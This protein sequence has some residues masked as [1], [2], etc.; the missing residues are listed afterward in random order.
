MAKSP[1]VGRWAGNVFGTNTGRVLLDLEE[2]NGRLQGTIRI[3]DSVTGLAMYSCSGDTGDVLDLEITPVSAQPGVEVAG[4]RV[5]GY[6]R[7]DG[8]VSGD[9]ETVAGTAGTFQVF[10]HTALMD[11][12]EGPMPPVAPEQ[13]FNS[14]E[15][16]GAMRLYL[17]DLH[18][19]FELVSQDFHQAR[20]VVTYAYRGSEK[21][22]YSDAFEADAP[23]VA[24]LRALRVSL[25]EPEPNGLTKAVN[26]QLTE[27]GPSEILVSG[28]S[29][30]WV[31]GKSGS[32]RN[33]LREHEDWLV[34]KYRKWGLAINQLLL[35]MMIV[36]SPNI[37]DWP[38]RAGFVASIFLVQVALLFAYNRLVPNTYIYLKDGEPTR[39]ERLWPSLLSWLLAATSSTVA[40]LV[41]WYFTTRS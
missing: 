31:L 16:V 24:N 36:V 20:P 22:Q 39:L 1:F 18:R 35:L 4:G 15:Q 9:W 38:S 26:I 6:L 29:E 7:P 10:P 13:A 14:T 17:R 30:S 34:S 11:A 28:G 25:Q 21:V 27:H 33:Y 3:N 40:G 37:A 2:K 5:R 12:S 8:S 32:I 41:V 23:Q 19:L